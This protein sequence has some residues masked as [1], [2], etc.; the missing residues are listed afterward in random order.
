MTLTAVSTL[1]IHGS[2]S[3][4][5]ILAP[6]N[7]S[8]TLMLIKEPSHMSPEDVLH[9]TNLGTVSCLICYETRNGSNQCGTKQLKCAPQVCWFISS[10]NDAEQLSE[11][12]KHVSPTCN[13]TLFSQKRRKS[14]QPLCLQWSFKYWT[15]L[16]CQMKVQLF[17]FSHSTFPKRLHSLWQ[18]K[19]KTSRQLGPAHFY[20][21]S[22]HFFFCTVRSHSTQL[23]CS[24]VK[25]P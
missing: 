19:N 10:D 5:G 18:K 15:S 14:S 20:I 25:V 4:V 17:F 11:Q 22:E 24:S 21:L 1:V 13:P 2:K 8:F 9:R 16:L 7:W 3:K 6:F 12:V 23:T